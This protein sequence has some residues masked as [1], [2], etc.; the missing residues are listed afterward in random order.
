MRMVTIVIFSIILTLT[1]GGW[2]GMVWVEG[3]WQ[4]LEVTRGHSGVSAKAW[5]AFRTGCPAEPTVYSNTPPLLQPGGQG[6]AL[7]G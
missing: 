4:S 6:G 7:T 1:P 3:W 5:M 2:G